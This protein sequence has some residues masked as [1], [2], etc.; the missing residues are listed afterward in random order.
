MK[1]SLFIGRFQPLHDGHIALF[2]KV[3]DE[4]KFV[5]IALRKTPM[6]AENP[7]TIKERREM[8]RIAFPHITFPRLK[9]ITIDD[10][11]AVCYGREVGYE[12]RQIKLDESIEAIS[13]TDIRRGGGKR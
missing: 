5:L 1:Y 8:I 6:D 2:Q 13:A 10:I 11:E 7:Y 9:V 4:G 3:L 12:I